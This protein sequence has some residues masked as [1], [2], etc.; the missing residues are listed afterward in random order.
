MPGTELTRFATYVLAGGKSRRFGSD[1]AL[2]TLEGVP[3]IQR[4]VQALAP[5]SRASIVV[6]EQAGKY[7][8][9]GLTTIGDVIPDRGPLG[10]LLTAL[11]HAHQR[12]E[13]WCLVLTCDQ[14]VFEPR[15]VD[16]LASR[17]GGDDG[18]RAA[19][20]RDDRWQPFP[21]LYHASLRGEAREAVTSG[22]LKMGR[23]LDAIAARGVQ[24]P[25]DWPELVQAN[26]REEL[27]RLR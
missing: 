24:L 26:T 27:E 3:L 18:V 10:G 2:A 11:E 21:A 23:F 7:A 20:F 15:W 4:L 16:A 17:L 14:V 13:S 12:D 19:A 9:L 6:A 25:A 1:K 5:V 22:R 8:S